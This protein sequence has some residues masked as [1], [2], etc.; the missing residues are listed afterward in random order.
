MRIMTSNIWGDYF[1]NPTAIRDD[2]LF[3]VYKKYAPD[4][5][6]M[7]E[8]TASW[9][10]S[11][12]LKNLSADYYFIG[13]ELFEPNNYIPLAIKKKSTLLAKGY[14]YIEQPYDLSKG[15]TWAV[16]KLQDGRIV[17]L[18]NT[19]FWWMQGPEHTRC[20]NSNA[21]QLSEIMRYIN[22]R[23][24][25]PVFA[26]GDMNASMSDTIFDIYRAHGMA[27]LIE[28]AEQRDSTC[29]HHGNPV[30]GDDG[31]YHGSKVSQ[32]RLV[33]MRQ[34]LGVD[35]NSDEFD[36]MASIDHIVGLGDGYKVLQYRVVEDQDALDATD[37]S[38]VF[39]DIEFN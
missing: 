33:R 25:C 14:E 20:R 28:L 1:G 5:I 10:Q 12:L 17:G 6:G 2:Q 38:P 24:S 35:E 22:R 7:Q 16:V 36:Y 21:E 26:L 15:V 8:V 4:V 31:R 30:R 34:R 37:H 23:Y 3:E 32:E 11:S 18:C 13:T 9:Y 39:A 27:P 29:S 19:H